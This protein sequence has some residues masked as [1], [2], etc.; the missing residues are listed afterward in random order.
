MPSLHDRASRILRLA[1][2]ITDD[3]RRR[4]LRPGD[5]YQNTHETAEMLGVSTT[6]ANRAMQVLVKRRLLERRQRKGTF[7]TQPPPDASVTP[8]RRVHLLV[9]ENYLRTEGLLSDG[10]VVGM[11]EALPAAQLQFNFMPPENEERFVE[12]LISEAMRSGRGEGFVLVRASL[13]VQR[14]LAGSGLP[15]VVHGSLHPSIERL[16]WIDR[17]H[18]QAGRLIAE[19]LLRQ[20]VSRMLVL[21]RDR[22]FQGDHALLDTLFAAVG[23]A[24]LGSQAITLRCLP[25]DQQAIIAA[26]RDWIGEGSNGPAGIICRSEPLAKG[27]AAAAVTP[28]KR[29]RVHIILSDYYRRGSEQPPAWPHLKPTL[30]PEEIGTRIGRMLADQARQI[31]SARAARRVSPAPSFEI[32]P[33]EL[34]ITS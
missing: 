34:E 9:Q 8:L 5:P 16:D 18:V 28:R 15:V 4:R 17:D 20:N 32:I 13:Q 12:E 24:N 19:H 31:T 22:M 26:T 7:V 1:D 11:H 30:S 10:V 25:S 14:L 2:A 21:M 27:A 23:E 33:V 29:N 3:I 6:A